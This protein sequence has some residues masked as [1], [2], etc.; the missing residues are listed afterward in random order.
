MSTTPRRMRRAS[1]AVEVGDASSAATRQHLDGN[2]EMLLK[3]ATNGRVHVENRVATSFYTEY[4]LSS[5]SRV[6]PTRALIASHV[7]SVLGAGW[8]VYEDMCDLPVPG[9]PAHVVAPTQ[10]LVLRYD[11]RETTARGFRRYMVE[12]AL[13]VC[14]LLVTAYFMYVLVANRK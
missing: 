7:K 2:V 6:S 12:R 11:H 10:T 14:A 5:D 13:L 3:E 1:V 8:Q 4:Y 9:M